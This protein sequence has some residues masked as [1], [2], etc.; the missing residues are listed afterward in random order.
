MKPSVPFDLPFETHH[1]FSVGVTSRNWS[2]HFQANV[3][4]TSARKAP[5]AWILTTSARSRRQTRKEFGVQWEPRRNLLRNRVVPRAGHKLFA[6]AQMPAIPIPVLVGVPGVKGFVLE[7]LQP[8]IFC[9]T[10]CN[11]MPGF[12]GAMIRG[13][14]RNVEKSRSAGPAL[15]R[16]KETLNCRD[17]LSLTQAPNFCWT[18]P[19]RVLPSSSSMYTGPDTERIDRSTALS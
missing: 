13:L 2:F 16:A 11:V 15:H 1:D 5:P 18:H 12:T 4:Y 3:R 17:D 7:H 6:P 10:V 9:K 8:N 14:W 19:Q